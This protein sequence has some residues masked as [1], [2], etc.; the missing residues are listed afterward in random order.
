LSLAKLDQVDEIDINEFFA[1]DPEYINVGAL[2]MLDLSST[3]VNGDVEIHYISTVENL[4]LGSVGGDLICEY[5]DL[6]KI[7]F[8]GTSIGGDFKLENN[9][10]LSGIDAPNLAR[11]EGEL[12]IASNF[13]WNTPGSGL[14]TMPSFAALTYIGGNVSIASN[15]NLTNVEAFNNVTEVRGTEIEFSANGNLDNLNIFNALVDTANPGTQWGD[16]SHANVNIS[17]NTF[18]F[19]GFNSL[20]EAVNLNVTVA[21]TAG[22]FNEVTGEFEPGGDTAKF[23]GFDSLTDVSALSLTVSEVTEFNAFGALNNFKH[24]QT[25]FTLYMPSDANVGLCSMSS[26][27]TKIKNGDFDSPWNADKKAMFLYNWAEQDRDAAIDQLLAPCA[28]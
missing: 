7:T 6:S 21:K 17:A 3:N 16:Y 9:K 15:S 11:I 22:V 19:T 18:W 27:L 23:E 28:I 2:A 25:Y 4:A 8:D 5:S 26:V 1:D 14:T 13:D 12:R 20:V 10:F 24:Y